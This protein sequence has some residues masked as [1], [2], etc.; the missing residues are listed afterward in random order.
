MG[1]QQLWLQAVTKSFPMMQG[2]VITAVSCNNCQSRGDGNCRQ[3]D[4][5][6]STLPWDWGRG[7]Q[8]LGFEQ[9]H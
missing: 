9:G 4:R 3:L 2:D 7:V 5:R 6:H 1:V 8:L